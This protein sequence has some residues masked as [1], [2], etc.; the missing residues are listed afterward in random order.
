MFLFVAMT[1]MIARLAAHSVPVSPSSAA[2]QK[3]LDVM[4]TSSFSSSD[5]FSS[6]AG[7]DPKLGSLS[8]RGAQCPSF[9]VFVSHYN[10]A[11]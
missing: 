3:S 7:G 10:Q 11:P 1:M 4:T 5:S 6:H 8:Q 9:S 2:P